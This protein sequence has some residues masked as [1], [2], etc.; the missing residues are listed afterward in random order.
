MSQQ[1][2]AA[3]QNANAA[4][5][6]GDIEGFLSFCVDDIIWTTVGGETLH[7]KE[8]VRQSMLKEY[9]EPPRFTVS[10]LIAEGDH[11]VAL[12]TIVSRGSDGRLVNNRYSDVWRFRDGRMAELNAFVI[13][14][15]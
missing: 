7:G 12:G 10:H 1:N 2:K 15:N 11:V 14:S 6:V 9:A 4:I 8:A 3:L 5:T 13:E